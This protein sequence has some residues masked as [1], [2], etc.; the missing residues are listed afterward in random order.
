MECLDSIS[1]DVE[2]V[3]WCLILSVANA[4]WGTFGKGV[5]EIVR[6]YRFIMGHM[7]HR[8][9]HFSHSLYEYF[10]CRQSCSFRGNGFFYW[11]LV[12]LCKYQAHL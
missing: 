10:S 12:H 1:E 7:I 9:Y 3:L 5:G 4:L 8:A 6:D 11:T 2:V